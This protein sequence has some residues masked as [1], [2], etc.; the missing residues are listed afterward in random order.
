MTYGKPKYL[1]L[2]YSTVASGTSEQL[3]VIIKISYII[4]SSQ[5]CFSTWKLS[6]ETLI[7]LFPSQV[8]TVFSFPCAI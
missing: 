6:L 8:G 1:S 4:S 2:K 3:L 5:T 7:P